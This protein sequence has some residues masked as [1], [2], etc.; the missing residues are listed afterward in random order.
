MPRRD[1]P[2]EVIR[3]WI[4]KAENDLKNASFTLTMDDDC[5]TDTIC[6]HAQQCVEKYLK[7]FL[8]WKGTPFPKTH[9]LSSLISLLPD[10]MPALLSEAEQELLTDYATVTRYPGEVEEISLSDAKKAVN[11]AR[12]V[13]KTLRSLLPKESL[14]PIR[15]KKQI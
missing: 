1:A 8:V 3:E 5:P 7:A 4:V 14:P 13:R 6:F 10:N 2:F 11:L 9:N 15:R 12:R